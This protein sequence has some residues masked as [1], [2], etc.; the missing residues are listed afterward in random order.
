M[1]EED[2]GVPTLQLY[3]FDKTCLRVLQS[4]QGVLL[5]HP[6][7]FQAAFSALVSEGE[8]FAKTPEGREL[9]TKLQCSLVVQQLQYVFDLGTLS[10]LERNPQD[11]LPSEYIDTLFML[12]NSDKSDSLLD[13]L[14]G[15]QVS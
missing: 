6:V 14:F 3:N 1:I 10:I 4:L 13:D 9:K 12:A 7:A 15:R 2:Q 5:K 11:I 8:E